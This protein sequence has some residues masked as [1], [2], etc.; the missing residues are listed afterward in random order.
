MSARSV[1][2][3]T[4]VER[5]LPVDEF[6]EGFLSTFVNKTN[7]YQIDFLEDERKQVKSNMDDAGS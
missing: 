1:P 3:S 2:V 6:G 5:S 7:Q 4:H